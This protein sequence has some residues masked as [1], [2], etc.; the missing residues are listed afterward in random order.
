MRISEK[1]VRAGYFWT[2]EAPEKKLPG[3]LTISD[4]GEI[5]LEVIG[6]FDASPGL[7]E[8]ADEMDV[9]KIIGE[10]E[11]AG[12]VTIDDCLYRQK[13][14]AFGGIAKSTLTG[15]RALFGVHLLEPEPNIDTY[16]CSL[17]GLD[18]WVSISGIKARTDF[19]AKTATI[20]FEPPPKIS[21]ELGDGF[22]FSIAFVWTAP[23][24]GGSSEAKIT[25][26]AYVEIKSKKL[27][28]LRDFIYISYR[29]ANFLALALDESTSLKDVTISSNKIVRDW[30]DG[31]EKT[32]RPV[33]IETYYQ[34]L[35]FSESEPRLK[36][37]NMLF[38]F[39]QVRD[40]FGSMLSSWMS[41]YEVFGPSLSL[42]FSSKTGGHKYL[43]G[44][45]LALA[46]ALETYHRRTTDDV[47]MDEKKF[48]KL[49]KSL[50]ESCPE[51]QK[52]WLKGRLS[53]GN[54]LSLAK[55]LKKVFDPYKAQLGNSTK[56]N[57]FIR[58]VV[59]TRNYLTHYSKELE[60]KSA[61]GREL[62]DTCLKM[63]VIFQLC[64][65]R[66]IGLTAA[67]V[68]DIAAQSYSI[69]QKLNAE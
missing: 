43:E 46:Q 23:F 53:F 33:Q 12:F 67:E 40:R 64:L 38:T 61:R 14:F 18:E 62:W 9:K 48:K 59:D 32:T 56:R 35:P 66:D 41:L 25:Q 16:R 6:N 29:F 34:S 63:E 7:P 45:F 26:R 58:K 47:L 20:T 3:T 39:P 49:V 10:I 60:S 54:E 55:R 8:P 69:K 28:P 31:D 21:H 51:E 4:G 37:H 27:R 52:D 19:E 44:K 30:G 15:H 36:R 1:I 11:K 50:V 68:S 5:E 42:Y 13:N 65:L 22:T 57:K 17:E 24:A 2:P